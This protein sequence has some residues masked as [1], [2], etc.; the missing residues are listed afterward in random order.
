[1]SNLL[2]KT[3]KIQ[4]TLNAFPVYVQCRYNRPSRVLY[5]ILNADP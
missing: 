4:G 2:D 3:L 5:H 1:M